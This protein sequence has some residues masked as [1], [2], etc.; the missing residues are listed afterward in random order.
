MPNCRLCLSIGAAFATIGVLFPTDAFLNGP[1]MPCESK[2]LR[3]RILEGKTQLDD[4]DALPTV[5]ETIGL[6]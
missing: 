2:V 4:L 3:P 6:R 1:S 5:E